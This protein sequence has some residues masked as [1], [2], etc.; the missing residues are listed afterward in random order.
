MRHLPLLS[1]TASRA[2]RGHELRRVG[3]M[4]LYQTL[5]PELP[6]LRLGA[7]CIRS[8]QPEHHHWLRLLS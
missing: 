6:Y 2:P 8:P 4:P 5:L 1:L 7:G 3:P